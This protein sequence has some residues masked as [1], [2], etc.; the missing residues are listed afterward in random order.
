MVPRGGAARI[1]TLVALIAPAWEGPAVVDQAIVFADLIPEGERERSQMEIVDALY[2]QFS[3]NPGIQVFPMNEPTLSID[4]NSSPVSF[5]V[6]GP[7]ISKV[8]AYADEIVRRSREIPGLINVESDLKLNK[9]QLV[10][11]VD[12]EQASDLGVSVRDVASTLQALLGG[13]EISTFKMHGETYEVIA[14]VLA[15]VNLTA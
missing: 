13:A 8:A 10:V 1:A 6:T 15:E 9:P 14:Q 11:H 7:K 5:V 4:W 3:A 12:R 2:V